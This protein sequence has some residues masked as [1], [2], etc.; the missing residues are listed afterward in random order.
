MQTKKSIVDKA[1]RHSDLN[2]TDKKPNKNTD[3][4]N[5]PQILHG[6]KEQGQHWFKSYFFNSMEPE[7]RLNN[8]S[9]FSSYLKENSTRLHKKDQLVNAV[10]RNNPFYSEN[11]KVQRGKYIQGRAG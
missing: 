5:Q 6:N 3:I 7:V 10:Q 11:R 8:I 1:N 4:R 2:I 9:T